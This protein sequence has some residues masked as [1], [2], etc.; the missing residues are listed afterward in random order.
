MDQV[1]YTQRVMVWPL[2][3]GLLGL[4]RQGFSTTLKAGV[5]GWMHTKD[6]AGAVARGEVQTMVGTGSNELRT[7]DFTEQ[8]LKRKRGRPR[9]YPLPDHVAQ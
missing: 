5:K 2:R 8:P 1:P 3:E 4:T 6:V 7:P 9:K